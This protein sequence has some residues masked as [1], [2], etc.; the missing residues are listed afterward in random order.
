MLRDLTPHMDQLIAV[1]TMI[2]AKLE[3]RGPDRR[4]GPAAST[5]ASTCPATTTQEPC[6]TLPEEYG[7]EPGSQIVGVVARLEPEKGHPTLL[8]AWPPCCERSRTPTC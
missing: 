2:E 4:T 1:S 7:M 5:T 8:E 6:C 3:R